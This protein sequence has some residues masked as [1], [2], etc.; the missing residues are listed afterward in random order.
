M[1][2]IT[3]FFILTVFIFT[4]CVSLKTPPSLADEIITESNKVIKEHQLPQ[5][6]FKIPYR[7][8]ILEEVL[9]KPEIK[10]KKE[11]L[12][13]EV[14]LFNTNYYS[15]VIYDL[16]DYTETQF[17][18]DTSKDYRKK[19]QITAVNTYRIDNLKYDYE[20]EM[21]EILTMSGIE[22]IDYLM[23][24]PTKKLLNDSNKLSL[25]NSTCLSYIKDGKYIWIKVY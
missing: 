2:A 5:H 7:K 12:V 6:F 19:P 18:F 10:E 8:Q 16:S 24:N 20:G 22:Y 23:K 15:Y 25:K 14:I 11:Y 3:Y 21:P 9:N 4:G 1:K 17:I 13:K